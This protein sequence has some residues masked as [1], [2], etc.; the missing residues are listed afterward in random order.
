[1]EGAPA[2]APDVPQ[3]SDADAPKSES[4]G[5]G[6]KRGCTDIICLIIFLASWGVYLFVTMLGF[7]DGDPQKLYRPRDYKGQFCGVAENW[8]NGLDLESQEKATYMMNVT[9]S[10][11]GIAKEF[12]CST[13][14]ENA[15]RMVWGTGGSAPDAAKLLA[16]ECGCC[17]VPC[18]TCAGSLDIQ[19]VSTLSA[20]SG[21]IGGK[22]GELTNTASGDLFSPSGANGDFFGNI[23]SQANKYFVPVCTTSCNSVAVDQARTFKYIPDPTTQLYET[24]RTLLTTPSMPA[25]IKNTINSAFTFQTLPSSVCPYEPRYCVPFPGVEFEELAGGIC[26]FKM[27]A[28]ALNAVGS[29][30][31][32]AFEGLGADKMAEKMMETWGSWTGDFI[33]TIDAFVLVAVACFIIGLIFLILLRFFVGCV[34]WLSIFIVFLL[35]LAGGALCYI[36]HTQCKGTD[37]LDSG[38]QTAVNVA[39]AGTTAV[40]GAITGSS[41]GDEGMTGDGEDY[42]GVQTRTRTY[43]L[44][45]DW[46]T[47]VPH[48][49]SYTNDTHPNAGLDQNYCRNPDGAAATIWCYTMDTNKKWE[50]CNPIGTINTQCIAGYEVESEDM[51]KALEIFAFV[52]WG[53][54]ALWLLFVMI[55]CKRILLAIAVNRVA[56]VFVSNTPSALLVPIGQTFLGII[57]CLAWTV[58]AAFLLS[59]VPDDHVPSTYFATY[60]EAYGTADTEGKCTGAFVNGQ[61]YKYEGNWASTSDP[62]SGNMGDITGITPQCWGCYPPRYVVDWRFAISFFCFLWNNAFLIATGQFIIAV[63][64][65]IWFFAP[66]G[67]KNKQKTVR[68]GVWYCFRYHLG[69]LALGSFIL[70]VVQF[71]RYALMYFEKQASA[72]KNR[73]AAIVMRIVQCCLYCLEKCIKFLNKNAYIQIALLGTPFCTSAKNAFFLILRNLARF[74]WVA[75]LGGIIN[76]IGLAF[77]VV[78]TAVAGYFVLKAMHPDVTPVLPMVVYVFM[79]Y[80]VAKL[81][82]N[83]FHLAVATI[84][85]CFLATEE[86]GGDDGF[87]PSQMRGLVQDMEKSEKEDKDVGKDEP[88]QSKSI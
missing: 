61:V 87:V 4:R 17:K 12:M 53:V 10:V 9:E 44:C 45:Q 14:V 21:K 80:L 52:L 23:W 51:R 63:A 33:D 64:V 74:G 73:V 16:Y 42:R 37:L 85:Q 79:A 41:I 57:W 34:V 11:D 48:Q 6:K 22:M 35:F 65:G 25:E 55:M 5:P 24:W 38:H 20:L 28:D 19:D 47:D 29:V 59:Q 18:G 75:L 46:N 15:L 54:A 84:L 30:A 76:F 86:Q 26:M 31:G 8:N 32:A 88:T 56:A 1:M 67:Q 27:S 7:A 13:V 72:A 78:A 68:T 3:S 83:V 2:P 82:M 39:I 49:T 43:R 66:R 69:S 36:R 81:F 77:I 62:C 70:A 40:D 60:A 71:I 58:S 50:L